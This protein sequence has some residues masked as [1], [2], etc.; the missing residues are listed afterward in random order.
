MTAVQ[1]T[2]EIIVLRIEQKIWSSCLDDDIDQTLVFSH[3]SAM[4]ESVLVI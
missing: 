1:Q 2:I 4:M 3:I